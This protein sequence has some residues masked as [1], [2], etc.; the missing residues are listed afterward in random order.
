MK[1]FAPFL[2]LVLML[3]LSVG[4]KGAD[5]TC[6]KSEDLVVLEDQSDRCNAT[7]LEN[8]VIHQLDLAAR[9]S[10]NALILWGDDEDVVKKL[11]AF[12]DAYSKTPHDRNIDLFKSV[13]MIWVKDAGTLLDSF[14]KD[15]QMLGRDGRCFYMGKTVAG[16]N[17]RNFE[18]ISCD[19]LSDVSL[20]VDLLLLQGVSASKPNPSEATTDAG[21]AL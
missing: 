7:P 4:A 17:A 10:K 13:R 14:R 9:S 20:A 2:L 18:Q 6:F 3:G 8:L 19:P 21:T 16:S 1:R 5:L 15:V 11:G 12:C